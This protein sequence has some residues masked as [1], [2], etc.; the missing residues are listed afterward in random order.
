MR[1]STNDCHRFGAN[2]NVPTQD[3]QSVIETLRH[4]QNVDNPIIGRN[5]RMEPGGNILIKRARTRAHR[6]VNMWVGTKDDKVIKISGTKIS[7]ISSTKKQVMVIYRDAE[8][9]SVVV[10]IPIRKV[11]KAFLKKY[12]K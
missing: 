10:E 8:N 11:D 1:Q 7:R 9:S 6:T 3:E 4:G 5:L 12:F 2:V